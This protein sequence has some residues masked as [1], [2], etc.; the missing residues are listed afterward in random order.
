ML[1]LDWPWIANLPFLNHPIVHLPYIRFHM[2]GMEDMFRTGDKIIRVE[3]FGTVFR[4]S[5]WS[6]NVKKYELNKN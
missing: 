6:L 4:M 1:L 5:S 2:L 3:H